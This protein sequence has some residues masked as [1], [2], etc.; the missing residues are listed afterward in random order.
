MI[1][2][3]ARAKLGLDVAW[4]RAAREWRDEARR[5]YETRSHA[6]ATEALERFFRAFAAL[7]E[8]IEAAEY[9]VVDYGE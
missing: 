4:E 9:V 6:P 8:A 7:E 1:E 5:R 3:L 2:D